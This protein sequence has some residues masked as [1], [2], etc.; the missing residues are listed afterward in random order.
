MR[1]LLLVLSI[2]LLLFSCDTE[3]MNEETGTIVNPFIGTWK[4]VESD[5]YIVFT[6]IKF[7]SYYANGN[8]YWTGLYTYDNENVVVTLDKDLS[9]PD[10]VYVYGDTGFIFNS[11]KFEADLL[12]LYS[13]IEHKLI[14]V[15]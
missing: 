4:Y 1:K 10:M 3:P 9:H 12:Y 6:N 7:T 8:I 15:N 14:K 13:P 2:V 11:Y 5:N